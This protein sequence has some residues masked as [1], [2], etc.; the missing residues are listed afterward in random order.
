MVIQNRLTAPIIK[1][2]QNGENYQIDLD[3]FVKHILLFDHYI[4]N[5]TRL[6][7]IPKLLE[8]FSFQGFMS[9]LESG[10]CSIS[11]FP[12]MTASLGPAMFVDDPNPIPGKIRPPTNYSLSYVSF[13]QPLNELNG[14]IDNIITTLNLNGRQSARLGSSARRNKASPARALRRTNMA[15][16]TILFSSSL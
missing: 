11:C 12:V 15:R 6:L 3:A 16:V 14:Y 9:L 5:S 8:A 2:K 13:A 4:L 1:R 10:A 7:E